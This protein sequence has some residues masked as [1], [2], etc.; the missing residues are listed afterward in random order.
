MDKL[1]EIEPK[2]LPRWVSIPLGLLFTPI[3]MVCVIGSGSLLLAPNVPRTLLTMS[4][5]T[6]F[7]AGSLWMFYISLRLLAVSP[8]KNKRLISPLGLK[9]I[10]LVF[11][12]IPIISIFLGTFWEK[13]II[14][15]VMT[16]AYITIIVRLL[17]LAK[18]RNEDVKADG[19][20]DWP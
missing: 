4:L 15:S 13:P 14:H 3:T 8:K 1:E 6:L 9:I 18:N 11:A 16:L 5:G 19:R 17:G 20:S 2:V 7:L 12:A 10:A